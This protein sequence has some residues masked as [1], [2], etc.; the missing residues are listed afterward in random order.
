MREGGLEAP[1]RHG[2]AW[3]DPEFT[4]PE[5]I[6]AE[7]RRVFGICHTCWRCFNLRDSFLRLFDLID[8]SETGELDSV[9][10]AGFKPVVEACTLCGMCFKTRCPYVPPH[11]WAIDFP[12]LM[13]RC[14]AAEHARGEAPFALRQLTETDRNGN[15]ARLAP[16]L[17]NW[18]SGTSNSMTRPVMEPALAVHREAAPGLSEPPGRRRGDR[19]SAVRRGRHRGPTGGRR[20]PHLGRRQGPLG[21]VH[22]F[23]LH[24]GTG[25]GV[26]ASRPPG[27]RRLSPPQLRPHGGHARG[28]ARL[29]GRGSGLTAT[30]AVVRAFAPTR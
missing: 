8:E 5:K 4:D 24:P 6:D 15:L 10:S 27:H 7:L 26:Q 30:P 9:D 23:P 18:A 13:L 2:I 25:R 21:A 14:P 28:G 1:T 11:E 17:A 29:P 22:S 3:T 20:R 12:H 19:V 16:G